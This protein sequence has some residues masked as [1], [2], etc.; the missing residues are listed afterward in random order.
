MTRI[1]H[2]Q[3]IFIPNLNY[4]WHFEGK[5]YL[6]MHVVS[7]CH[8]SC[9]MQVAVMKFVAGVCVCVFGV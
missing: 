4:S 9:P 5:L 3:L 6:R 7:S 8:L 2:I 1:E